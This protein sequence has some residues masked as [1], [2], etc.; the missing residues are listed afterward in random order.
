MKTFF[1][2]LAT[3][4]ALLFIS[5]NGGDQNKQ[6]SKEDTTASVAVAPEPAPF[7]PFK[8]M[9]VKQNVKSYA[10]WLP[11]FKSNDSLRNA[12]DVHRFVVG[13]GIPDSNM[14]VVINKIGD[15][16]KAKDFRKLP[17]L[18][19]MMSKGGVVGTPGISFAEVIRNDSTPVDQMDRMMVSHHVKNFDAWL[20]TFDA[21]TKETRASYGMMD[22]AIARDADDSNMVYLVFVITDMAKAKARGESAELKKLMTDAGVEGKTT[23]TMYKIVEMY[24]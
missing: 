6:T 2:S 16:Q 18:K 3:G 1:A 13:R 8:V 11:L 7:N 14:V 24:R 10:S 12:Y 22:R 17:Q 9:I 4:F 21:E 19:Q 20:K 5:C 15:F 23:M